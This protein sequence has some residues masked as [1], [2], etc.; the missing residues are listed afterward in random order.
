MALLNISVTD[1]FERAFNSQRGRKFDKKEI[2][3]RSFREGEKFRRSAIDTP[4]D[5][6]APEEGTNFLSVRDVVTARGKNGEPLFMPVELG[7]VL[8]PNE[9][10]LRMR[11]RKRIV[12][13]ELA[14]S[15]LDGTVKELINLGDWEIVIRGIAVNYEST[16]VFPED[17]A[18]LVHDL[19]SRKESLEIVSAITS[20]RSVYRVVIKEVNYPELIGVQHAFA[21]EFICVSDRY[22]TLEID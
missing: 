15:K 9:P 7:G 3:E 13:T 22:F 4:P 11:R 10:T 19:E 2:Q 14:G 16:L 21:Y 17:Q 1:L 18:K 5:G 12:M 20:L 6:I 8:L